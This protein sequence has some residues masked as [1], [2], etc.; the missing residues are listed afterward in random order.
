MSKVIVEAILR[1]WD[2][3]RDYAMRL[4]ADLSQDDMISQPVPGV[5][6]NHPAWVFSHIGLYPPVLSAILR[7]EPF[8][9][10]I[11]SPYGKDSR[12]L[13]EAAAYAEKS[14]LMD[15]YF[16]GH[17]DLAATLARADLGVLALPIPLARW[18][19]RFP[20]VADAII[21]LMIDHEMGHLGQISAWRRA[22]KRASV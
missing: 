14:T 13:S 21:H 22:G 3:Q 19:Q 11:N 12:P 9:D 5:I 4:V 20:F 17:D 1:T 8:E 6:M 15:G 10:P 7:G 16:R 2:R 18:K